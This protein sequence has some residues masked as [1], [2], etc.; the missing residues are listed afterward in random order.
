MCHNLAHLNEIFIESYNQ[1][2]NNFGL[3]RCR[4]RKYF[5]EFFPRSYIKLTNISPY[6]DLK[7]VERP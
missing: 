2:L 7:S 5:S 1:N 6:K 4:Y 3:K